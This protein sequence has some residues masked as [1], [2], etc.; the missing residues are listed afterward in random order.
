MTIFT[1]TNQGRVDK[2][3]GTL[4]LIQT[5]A[6]S[7][8]A[9]SADLWSL[10]SPAVTSLES[11]LSPDDDPRDAEASATAPVGTQQLTAREVLLWAQTAPL[12][13]L[14]GLMHQFMVRLDQE[15]Y[16]KMKE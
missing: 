2:I 9:T 5:S 14:H 16:P 8:Q 15:L 3:V 7:N 4:A 13:D 11:L 6:K 1:P 10:L 12:R